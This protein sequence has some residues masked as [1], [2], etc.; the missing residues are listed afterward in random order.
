MVKDYRRKASQ[1][2]FT[3]PAFTVDA[4][5]RI[6]ILHEASKD[7][8]YV[9]FSILEDH[10]RG[11]YLEGLVEM[12][13]SCRVGPVRRLIGPAIVTIVHKPNDV[14]AEIHVR[15]AFFQ[16]GK[17]PKYFE[18]IA[19]EIVSIKVLVNSGMPM[20]KIG[21]THQNFFVNYFGLL[22][23]YTKDIILETVHV[24][25]VLLTAVCLFS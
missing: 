18:N 14:I 17:I 23:R 6:S 1:W 10:N 22:Q 3:Y 20:E 9:T 12:S 2:S 7:V 15:S 4:V 25:W 5:D 8:L 24:V 16:F 13:R 21:C 19:Q 11:R